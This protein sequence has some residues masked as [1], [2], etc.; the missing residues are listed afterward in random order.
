MRLR[1]NCHDD[2]V[3]NSFLRLLKREREHSQIYPSR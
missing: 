1:G 3:G 2:A